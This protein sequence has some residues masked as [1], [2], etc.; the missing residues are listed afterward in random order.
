MKVLTPIM[1]GLLSTIVISQSAIADESFSRV[2]KILDGNN[3][4]GPVIPVLDLANITGGSIT[5]TESLEGQD[6]YLE[7][8]TLKFNNA[9]SIS[10]NR[11][12][13]VNDGSK[14]CN[15]Y[16][17]Y[18]SVYVG[19]VKNQ[20]L[21]REVE[22]TICPQSYGPMPYLDANYT[23]AA[24]TYEAYDSA[25]PS[26]PGFLLASGSFHGK[27][28]TPNPVTDVYT[29]TIGGKPLTLELLKHAGEVEIE[30]QGARYGIILN[31]N[32]MGHGERQLVIDNAPITPNAS[33]IAINVDVIPGPEGDVEMIRISYQDEQGMQQEVPPVELQYLVEQS[34]G[35]MLY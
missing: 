5:V 34:Y 8:V 16:S 3:T 2:F 17:P 20:W 13:R 10:V 21:F 26:M 30:F 24:K 1:T 32:W 14:Q 12:N 19:T 29:T 18:Q 9:P 25:T 15:Y 22:V 33:T 11:L 7:N 28:V 27:D 4:S 6:E 31:A 35:P 23:I